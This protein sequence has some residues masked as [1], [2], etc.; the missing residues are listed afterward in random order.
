ME[1]TAG[2]EAVAST[3]LASPR[4][5]TAPQLKSPFVVCLWITE[6]CNLSCAY[7]YA[8]PSRGIAMEEGR[9]LRLLDELVALEVFDI[10][11]AGGEPFLHPALLDTLARALP[12]GISVGILSNGTLLDEE[13]TAR[14]CRTV[15]AHGPDNFLLQVS[16]DGLDA[17]THDRSRGQGNR[18]LRNLQRLCETDLH[19]QIASVVTAYNIDQV[20]ALIDRYYPRVKRYH[21][22]N[23]Q[24][25]KRSLE[26]PELFVPPDRIQQFW[27]SLE[28]KVEAM[29]DDVLVTGLRLMNQLYRMADQP[30]R[31]LQ[32]S[33][34]RCAGCTAGVTHVDIRADFTV[35]GCDIAQDFTV[36]GNVTECS[37][38]SVWRSELA[39]AVRAERVPACY[40]IEAPDGSSL[41]DQAPATG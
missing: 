38:D 40:R 14:L 28:R 35:V 6:Q 15:D 25:T 10:T 1:L 24:R 8:A 19:L 20:D 23:L 21:F 17:S 30:G 13:M 22:M 32:R 5:A 2:L 3:T 9:L 4:A 33:T 16:L 18:V 39:H 29:P 34:F 26:R 31:H 27:Q 37:F 36:M 11:I 41:M 7:C 12:S